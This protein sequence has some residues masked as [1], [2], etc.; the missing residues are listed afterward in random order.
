LLIADI[1]IIKSADNYVEIVYKEGNIFRKSLIRNT[2][3]NIELQLKEYPNFICCH[4]I[5][6]VN[7]IYIEKLTKRFDTY[8]LTLKEFNEQIPVSR[9]Y[10][11]KLRESI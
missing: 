7:K 9:Q 6:I 2:L 10:L 11:L 3:K 1:A 4:R 8:W 5:C